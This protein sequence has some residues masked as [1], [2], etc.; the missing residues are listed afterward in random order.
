MLPDAHD[1]RE[2]IRVSRE[3]CRDRFAVDEL[4]MPAAGNQPGI[5]EDLQMM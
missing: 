1:F 5:I 4:P 2:R 3:R